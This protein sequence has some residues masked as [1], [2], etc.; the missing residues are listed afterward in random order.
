MATLPS[1]TLT[2]NP[3]AG[4]IAATAPADVACYI[5]CASA[6]TNFA[7]EDFGPQYLAGITS[8][9]VN[10][11]LVSD[12]GYVANKTP[13]QTVFVK[14]PATSVSASASAI[15]TSGIAGT[16]VPGAIG[17]TILD[18]YDVVVVITTAGTIGTSYAYKVSL[19]GGSTFGTPIS[20]TTSLSMAI[21]GTLNG[22]S[23]A[24]GIT[25]AL[26]TSQTWDLGDTF[27][28]WTQPASAS[29]LPQTTT[30]AG[31]GS[32]TST[33]TLSGTPNNEY[34]V[35][36]N[37]LVGGTEGQTG[38]Q[39]EYSLDGG[40]NWYPATNL[41]TGGAYVLQDGAGSSGLT[42]TV[43]SGTVGAGDTLYARTTAP[44][45]Q[46]ADV[47]TAMNAVR[48][49]NGVWSFFVLCGRS[50]RAMRDS[51]ESLM[52]TYATNGRYTFCAVSARDR[53]TGETV[54]ASQN[55]VA[56]DEAWSARLNTEWSTSAGNRTP[57][58]AGSARFTQPVY[59]AWQSR[60]SVALGYV[61]RVVGITPDR[62]PGDRTL[63]NNGALS[64]D[65]H[66]TDLNSGAL[67]E[68]DARLNPA[69]Y[70]IGF[71]VLRTWYGETGLQPGVFPAGGRLMSAATDIQ[72]WCHRRVL[73][74]ADAA[75]QTAAQNQILS[76]FSLWPA[77]VRTPYKGGDIY[78][79]D[80][81][82][83]LKQLYL[84]VLNAVRPYVS[85]PTSGGITV[86]V[87]PTP[88]VVGGNTTVFYDCQ[89]VWK[90]IIDSMVGSI[91]FTNPALN[92][93]STPP[94]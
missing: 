82:N 56:G 47:Q 39:F 33:Y 76:R 40:L 54:A 90:D 13:V 67:T 91:G 32:S 43:G 88:A 4:Q 25:V 55:N 49:W 1:A 77:T 68:H 81:L 48:N 6:G 38:I 93:T 46:F 72:R 69:L 31:M 2:E 35:L 17:G 94:G 71:N 89:L 19:D 50:T 75:I 65:T 8:T 63:P 3:P 7:I 86:T 20:V 29:I 11:P 74:L 58:H 85:N 92:S 18:G 53:I 34:E 16:A 73:N 45:P 24:T 30:R 87:T 70:Q 60:R 9:F 83:I 66:I 62:D 23:I 41:P 61:G 52:Q 27:S 79:P 84:A 22:V 15:N 57:P 28:F 42:L 44:V 80:R 59:P 10:G 64:A 78:E 26:T 51:I 14:V 36:V 37:F 21:T 5:G 12:G